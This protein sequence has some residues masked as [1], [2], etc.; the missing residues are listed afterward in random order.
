AFPL[1]EAVK[2]LAPGVYAIT[3]E[4]KEVVSGDYGQQATQWFIVSDLGLTAYSAH[5]GIDVFVHSLATAEPRGSV[6]VRL[7]ARNNEVLAVRQTDRNGF[8]HFEAG[9]A[10]GGGGAAAAAIRA[11]DEN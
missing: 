1:N 3:A 6:E 11:H 9:L 2:D 4:P 5:D 7:V 8:I 10:R